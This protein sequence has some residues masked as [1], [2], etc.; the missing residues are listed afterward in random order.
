MGKGVIIGIGNPGDEYRDTF[1]NEGAAFVTWLAGDEA[2]W[3]TREHV[4]YTQK[5]GVTL[6]L[7]TTYMNESGRAV[8]ELVDWFK[9]DESKL[10]VAHDDTDQSLGTVKLTE[11]GGSGGHK[12]I[13]SITETLGTPNFWRLKIGARP[14][15]FAGTPHIK[16]EN[17]VLN[18]L[19]SEE[20]ELL[21]GV[22]FPSG[23]KLA[24]NVMENKMPSGPERT[25]AIGSVTTDSDGSD[26]S[27]R[28]ND[29][30]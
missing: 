27:A 28:L 26:S 13:I 10:L 18:R 6:A 30:S 3:T 1:H 17:F 20:R 23:L 19:G 21:Y 25:S 7:T 12:G 4:R 15:R 5:D 16:A 11:G 9:L 8:R 14:E 2:S 22:A 24:W 29:K